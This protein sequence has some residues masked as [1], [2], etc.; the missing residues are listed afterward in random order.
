MAIEPSASTAHSST[1]GSGLISLVI[2][3]RINSAGKGEGRLLIGAK[4][5][6]DRDTKTIVL[7]D[8]ATQPVMLQSV[9]RERKSQ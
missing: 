8:Y 1:I 7:E 9:K 6:M 5:Q 4:I 2:D 3:M